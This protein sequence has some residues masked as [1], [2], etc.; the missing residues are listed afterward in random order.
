MKFCFLLAILALAQIHGGL[1]EATTLL[2]G[3]GAPAA[4]DAAPSAS[5]KRPF[6]LVRGP[7]GAIWVADYDANQIKRID[8]RGVL[9]DVVGDGAARYAGDGG[10]ATKASLNHPHEIRFDAA[11][12]L[13][14]ADTDNHV[15]RRYHPGTGLIDTYAG[16]GQ[17]GSSGDGGPAAQA[18]ISD[19][20]SLQFDHAGNLYIADVR[21]GVIRRVDAGGGRITTFAGNGAWGNTPDG[22]PIAGTPLTGPRSL[23][24]AANGDLWLVTR[25]HQLLRFDLAQGRIRQAAGTGKAGYDGDGGP[26]LEATLNGPKSISVAANGDVYLADTENH[27]IRRYDR[28]RGTL[29]AVAGTAAKGDALAADPRQTAFNL[30]HGIWVDADGS[31]LVSDSDNH[32][33][34]SIP[35]PGRSD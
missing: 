31:V 12:E 34:L 32:R 19:P 6:G 3:P 21:L 17:D 24:L 1:A 23:A 18:S 29:E 2:A 26:A 33:I 15:I 35:A 20:M 14:I 13:F 8:A 4:G 11:G 27:V 9:T 30:P 5:L 22:A 10:P 28:R 16:N 7:D 25:A